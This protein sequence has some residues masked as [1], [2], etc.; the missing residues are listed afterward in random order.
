MSAK[1]YCWDNAVV[2]SIFSTLKHEMGLD[3]DAVSLNSPQQLIRHL[4]FWIDGYYNRERRHSMRWVPQPDQLRAG[5][6]QHPYTHTRG[7]LTPVHRIGV[8]PVPTKGTFGM[9]SPDWCVRITQ[10]L[11]SPFGFADSAQG[12]PFPGSPL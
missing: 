5:V 6:H 7:A 12:L 10:Q 8:I 2:E 11:P 9:L 4:A 3:D 1:G